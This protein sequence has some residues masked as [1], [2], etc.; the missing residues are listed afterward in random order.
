MFRFKREKQSEQI[1]FFDVPNCDFK[2]L[3]LLVD[4]VAI[5]IILSFKVALIG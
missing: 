2:I 3:L 1:S 5:A 4:S